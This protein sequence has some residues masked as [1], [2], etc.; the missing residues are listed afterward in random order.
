[1]LRIIVI[2]GIV[3]GCAGCALPQPIEPEI[4]QVSTSV[5][6]DDPTCIVYSTQA[7]VDQAE[8]AIIGRACRQA[9][10]SW[11]ITEGSPGQ[12][13]ESTMVYWPPPDAYAGIYDPWLWGPPIGFSIGAVVFVDRDHHIHRIR[14]FAEFD[15]LQHHFGHLGHF[16]EGMGMHHG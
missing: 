14:D 5:A 3:L 10:G 4:S 7:A 8:R 16:A 11:K 13:T 15:H 2:A 12:P 1:M 9:D 6:P